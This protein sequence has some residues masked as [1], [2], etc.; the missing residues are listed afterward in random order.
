[1][2]RFWL[3]I[4]LTF[5][6]LGLVACGGGGGDEEAAT[7]GATAPPTSPAAATPGEGFT[8][9]DSLFESEDLGYRVQFPEGWTPRPDFVPAATFSTDAF[10]APDVI[11]EV[12]PNIAVTCDQLPEGTTLEEYFEVKMEIVR[13][14]VGVEPEVGTRELA[15]EEARTSRYRREEVEPPLEKA[16]AFFLTERCGWNISL[17]APLGRADEYEDVFEEF[18]DSFS[19]LP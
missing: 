10:F 1:M 17:T 14:N 2:N 4:I 3:A 12:Q 8:I 11:E 18:L 5:L 15:G 7:P 13:Q 19:L 9:S 16:E 6:G